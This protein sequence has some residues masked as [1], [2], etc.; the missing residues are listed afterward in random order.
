MS[1]GSA[2]RDQDSGEVKLKLK[3]QSPKLKAEDLKQ[4]Y[5]KSGQ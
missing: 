2:S 1:Y 5:L 3:A 4:I